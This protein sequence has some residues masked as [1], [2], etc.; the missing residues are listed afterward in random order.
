MKTMILRK[1]SVFFTKSSE[2]NEKVFCF[3]VI[4][5]WLDNCF[6]GEISKNLN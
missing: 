6:V 4:A 1:V 2:A 5:C 3:Q